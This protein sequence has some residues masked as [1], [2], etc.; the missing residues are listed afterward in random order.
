[1]KLDKIKLKNFR[2]YFEETIIDI[3]DLTVIVGRN[4]VGKSTILEA[5][6][7][8]FNSKLVKIE[9]SDLNIHSKDNELEITCIFSGLPESLSI[10]A[11]AKTS[12]ESEHLL[13]KDGKF[14]AVKIYNCAQKTPKFKVYARAYYPTAEGYTDLHQLKN[15]ELKSKYESYENIDNV[16]KRSNV[17]LR[18]AIWDTCVD[19]NLEEKLVSLEEEDGKKIWSK[20]EDV[21]P[22][23]ALFQSDRPSKDDDSEV[24]DPM[25]L[26]VDEALSE[27][28]EKL[29]NV[30]E[31]VKKQA[32]DVARRTI[33]KLK[34]IDPK[35]ARDLE[36]IFKSEPKWNSLFKLSLTDENS[37]PINKRGSGTRRLILLSFFRAEAER[38]RKLNAKHDVIYAIEEPETSQHPSNQALIVDTFHDLSTTLGS[39]ILLTTHV[40]GLAGLLPVKSIRWVKQTDSGSEV[41]NNL[42]KGDIKSVADELGVVPD[43]RAKVLLCVEGPTDITFFEE[44]SKILVQTKP[45]LPLIGIDPRVTVFPLGG[46]TLIQWVANN[47]TKNLGLPEVHIYDRDIEKPPK[48]QSA[49]DSVNQ[50][51]DG[52]IAV[53]TEKRE[54]ENYIHEDSITEVF[55]ITI[56][57]GDTDDIPAK[58]KTEVN[59]DSTNPYYQISEHRAKKVLMSACAKK[60]TI[61]RINSIDYNKEIESWFNEIISRL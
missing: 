27:L 42:K 23:F 55:G 9:K 2:S 19:L 36:P 53:L 20:I 4:D 7:I 37:I 17:Q 30:K 56:S 50:R 47:Y 46:S 52:S 54:M 24:Q 13:N 61:P 15:A 22:V 39:Q 3:D 59:N 60:M 51:G 58:V 25:K 18:K 12:L 57:V 35:L 8:F 11:R 1:M 34:E 33:D 5:L 21:L 32:T 49:V 14:E 40:P 6:E 29:D 44:I 48:Y 28:S 38:K 10:D 16:D 43:S 31:K 41:I 45:D 26:A